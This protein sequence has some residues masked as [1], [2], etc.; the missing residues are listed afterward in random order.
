M[1]KKINFK[2][3]GKR[4]YIHGTD[5][6]RNFINHININ[7]DLNK[8]IN[9]DMQIKKKTNFNQLI[10]S[11]INEEEEI[12]LNSTCEFYF[13]NVKIKLFMIDSKKIVNEYYDYNENLFESYILKK[14]EHELNLRFVDNSNKIDHL[15]DSNKYLLS[16][17]FNYDKWLFTRLKLYD[18]KFQ[19]FWNCKNIMIKF[20]SSILNIFVKTTLVVND[21]E[22]GEIFFYKN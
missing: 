13:E 12:I 15:I 6:F 7:F 22:V 17:I 11:K 9:F 20:T 21:I 1:N 4:D 10:S 8:I 5:I 16:K 3:K 14:K 19:N 18:D 2:F